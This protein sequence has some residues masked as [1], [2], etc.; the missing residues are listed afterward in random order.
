MESNNTL[1]VG[2]SLFAS[3]HNS[4]N[5]PP[6]LLPQW[7]KLA[8]CLLTICIIWHRKGLYGVRPTG[9]ETDCQKVDESD[10]VKIFALIWGTLFSFSLLATTFG[11]ICSPAICWNGSIMR[12]TGNLSEKLPKA[13]KSEEDE[14]QNLCLMYREADVAQVTEEFD[15]S[16]RKVK[17]RKMSGMLWGG[18][19]RVLYK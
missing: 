8:P 15:I 11:V 7:D 6:S 10:A 9:D 2:L 17:D 14:I 18:N 4:Q 1:S 12:S 13:R 5:S 3:L 16:E 19:L